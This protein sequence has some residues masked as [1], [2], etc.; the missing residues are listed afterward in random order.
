MKSLRFCVPLI[1]IFLLFSGCSPVVKQQFYSTDYVRNQ[2]NQVAVYKVN[3]P[4]PPEY[5]PIGVL[6]IRDS[7]FS[8]GCSYEEVINLA[9]KRA[10]E[11][12]ASALALTRVM[13]PDL[14]SSCYRIDAVLLGKRN[15]APQILSRKDTSSPGSAYY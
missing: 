4:Y 2:T 5:V 11:R 14:I 3:Q 9:C 13:E 15:P 10:L 8:V 6:T 12:G 7:G 1:L